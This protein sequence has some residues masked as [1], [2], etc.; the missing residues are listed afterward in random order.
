MINKVKFKHLQGIV[1]QKADY[2][3]IMTET[4]GF[5][6]NWLGRKWTFMWKFKQCHLLI[7]QIEKLE[8]KGIM[9]SDDCEIK[10]PRNIDNISFRAMM[11][12]Q[13]LLGN[14]GERKT[15]ELMTEMIAIACFESNVHKSVKYDSDSKQYQSFKWRIGE[16]SLVEMLGLYNWV[17]DALD[18]S[19]SL[20]DQR[21]FNVH[22]EDKDY[23]M[24]G[25][26]SMNSFNI[27]L[28]LKCVCRDFNVDIEEAWNQSY[29]MVQTNSLA[30]A[31]Q[32]YI[33]DQMRIIKEAKMRAEKK[34]N[35]GH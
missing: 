4:L 27:I 31:T 9:Y 3:E 29:A 15:T 28:T 25:G 26:S 32:N 10:H 2:T 6:N 11:E 23:E 7:K 1:D 33:Q 19:S 17:S 20:W 5:K 22:V 21:F 18:R 13:A 24:A 30:S 35:P 12:M 8:P 34:R 14:P 16:S